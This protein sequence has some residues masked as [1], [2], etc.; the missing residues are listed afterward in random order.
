M[1]G[2]FQ[3]FEKIQYSYARNKMDYG[4]ID[5]VNATIIRNTPLG[6]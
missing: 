2:H 6:L 5:G 1:L 4:F 3:V